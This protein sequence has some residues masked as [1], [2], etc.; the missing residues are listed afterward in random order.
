MP[1]MAQPSLDEQA[2]PHT[3]QIILGIDTHKDIH[4]AAL[5][6]VVGV[7]LA[8]AEFATTAVGY[9]QLLAWARG[10]GV[11]RRAGVEGTGCYGAALTRCLRRNGIT[12]IEVN[13]PD[14]AARR[15]QGKTDAIDAFAAARAV[16]SG[17]A[18]STGKTRDGPVQMLRMLRLARTSAVKS[19]T[20]RGIRA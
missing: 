4:V 13:R 1:S 8:S 16:L 20:H 18:T 14:H 6:T 19:R 10:F 3:E 12:V 9:R 5:I 11:L 17:R 15:R 7:E 2:N